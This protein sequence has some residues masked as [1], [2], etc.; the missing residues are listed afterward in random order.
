[1]E[2]SHRGQ[3]A[4]VVDDDEDIRLLVQHVL[5]QIGLE[6]VTAATGEEGIEAVRR[7]DPDLVTLDLSLPDVD[8]VEVCRRLREFSNAYVVMVTGRVE[9]SDRL[10]GLE[11]GADDYLSK[12]FSP[13]ELHARAAA[14]LRRPRAPMS[15]AEAPAAAP[16][17]AAAP[18][19]DAGGGLV[20]V[21]VDHVALLDG[22]PLPLTP[23]EVS[24]L[25]AFA[26]H[27]GRTW[28]RGDLVREVWEGEFIESDF[29]VDVHVAS[30]RRKLRKAGGSDH[31]WIRTVG[32]VGYTFQTPA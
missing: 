15:G 7:T 8:G 25:T 31:E 10:V 23:A 11:V 5:E 27:P 16:V 6:V 30:L 14:L 29:L 3:R 22:L 1:M 9:E 13:R 32:G 12:P 20:L 2:R 28:E 18:P 19:V 24:L 4:V 21:P 17:E 26:A